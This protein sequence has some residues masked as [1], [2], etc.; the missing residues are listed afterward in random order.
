MV[1][2]AHMSMEIYL[3]MMTNRYRNSPR[4]LVIQGKFSIR[5][6]RIHLTIRPASRL[7]GRRQYSRKPSESEES[8]EVESKSRGPKRKPKNEKRKRGRKKKEEESSEEEQIVRKTVSYY[9]LK[10]LL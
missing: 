3:K 9:L 2:V 8:V 1:P 10:P 5:F 7:S 4:L 6:R